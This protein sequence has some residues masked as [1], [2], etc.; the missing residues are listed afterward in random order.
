MVKK[1][2]FIKKLQM[3]E[4]KKHIDILYNLQK[5]NILKNPEISQ[6]YVDLIRKISTSLRIRLPRE[7]KRSYCK[8]CYSVFTPTNSRTRTQ[9]KKLVK[10]CFNCKKFTRIPLK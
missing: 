10:Y 6:R 4:A 7:I 1:N 9:N 2:N 3:T 5:E 8:H